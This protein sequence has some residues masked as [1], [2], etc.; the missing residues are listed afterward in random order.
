MPNDRRELGRGA[1]K[2]RHRIAEDALELNGDAL[3][4]LARLGAGRVENHVA[5]GDKRLDIR[6]AQLAELLAQRV[7]LHDVA[8]DID[9]A[10]QRD[11]PRTGIHS[12]FTSVI[13]GSA[14]G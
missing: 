12:I 11:V 2:R 5:T 3:L 13:D 6:E 9:G 4:E 14:R 8:A 7:H 1:N 10:Q